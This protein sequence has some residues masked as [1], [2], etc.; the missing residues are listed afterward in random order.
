MECWYYNIFVIILVSGDIMP[1]F[2]ISGERQKLISNFVERLPL[3]RK[4]V[5]LS[6]DDLGNMVGKSRQ[7]ISDIER[8][9]APMGWDTYVAMCTMLELTGVFDP[10]IDAW[11]YKD[12][13]VWLKT[14]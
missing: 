11:Y 3:I 13:S 14:M 6:Q 8:H 10:E 12:K 4:K 7:K 9:A 5:R 2:V 1:E